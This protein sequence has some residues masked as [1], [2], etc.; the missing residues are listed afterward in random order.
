MMVFRRVES[1]PNKLVKHLSDGTG[2]FHSLGNGRGLARRSSFIGQLKSD[3]HDVIEA[4]LHA[5]PRASVLGPDESHPSMKRT[6]EP[7]WRRYAFCHFKVGERG[8]PSS[9]FG[10]TRHDSNERFF[11]FPS[12]ES[13]HFSAHDLVKV[14]LERSVL[15]GQGEP[16][17]Y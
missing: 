14:D 7:S 6:T 15:K 1:E 10:T 8:F 3:K 4:C 16:L 17:G 12:P 5:C 9:T 13:S 11:L 2:V